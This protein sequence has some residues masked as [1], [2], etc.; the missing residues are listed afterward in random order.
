MLRGVTDDTGEGV[1]KRLCW[2]HEEP[3]GVAIRGCGKLMRVRG[4]L[5]VT[6]CRVPAGDMG[7]TKIIPL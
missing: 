4:W 7:L 6:D 2:I 3:L 1:W 5:A